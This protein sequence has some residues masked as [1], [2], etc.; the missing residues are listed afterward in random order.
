MVE[1]AGPVSLRGQVSHRT[2]QRAVSGAASGYRQVFPS[3]GPV[4]PGRSGPVRLFSALKQNLWKSFSLS[5]R[6]ES[7]FMRNFGRGAGKTPPTGGVTLGPDGSGRSLDS[8]A[9]EPELL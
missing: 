4:R 2:P 3:D 9:E 5:H 1:P 8:D 6:L 7:V